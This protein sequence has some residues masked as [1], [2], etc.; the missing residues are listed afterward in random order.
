MIYEEGLIYIF[1]IP[2]ESHSSW[3]QKT[4]HQVKFIKFQGVFIEKALIMTELTSRPER[5]KNTP[6]D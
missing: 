2:K 1:V 5:E 6:K 4:S 3:K